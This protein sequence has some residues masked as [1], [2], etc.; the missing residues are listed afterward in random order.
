MFYARCVSEWEHQQK[1]EAETTSPPLPPLCNATKGILFFSVPHRGSALA[2]IQAPMLSR[3]I[4]LMEVAKGMQRKFSESDRFLMLIIFL[5]ADCTEVLSL[6]T[7][8]L[9]LCK[10]ELFNPEMVS[11]F[12]TRSTLMSVVFL[13][14]VAQDSAG[15]HNI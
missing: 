6:H 7:R 12:E 15:M 10:Q 11:L 2:H 3:S 8:F 4:E 5:R 14:I 1:E 13:R 9:R